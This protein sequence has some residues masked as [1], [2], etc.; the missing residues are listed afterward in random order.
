MAAVGPAAQA[1]VITVK[2]CRPMCYGLTGWSFAR[3]RVQCPEPALGAWAQHAAIHNRSWL[4]NTGSGCGCATAAAVQRQRLRHYRTRYCTAG[5]CLW[6]VHH[7]C[8]HLPGRAIPQL[9]KTGRWARKKSSQSPQASG[10]TR[11]PVASRRCDNK[12]ARRPVKEFRENKKEAKKKFEQ[13]WWRRP[14]PKGRTLP[15]DFC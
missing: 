5:A 4:P 13:G 8:C 1:E 12:E 11:R 3:G 2:H 15:P 7:H 9:A 14:L 10:R 6:G